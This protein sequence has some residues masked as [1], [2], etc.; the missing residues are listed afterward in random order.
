MR[1]PQTVCT[2]SALP[3]DRLLVL[4]ER[5]EREGR[6]RL[7]ARAALHTGEVIVGNIGSHARLDYTVIGDS[8]NL[9]SRLEGLNKRYGTSLMISETTYEKVKDVMVVRPLDRVSVKGKARSV[10][11]YE[12][13]GKRG[14]VDDAAVA[15]AERHR[16]AFS[17]YLER[18]FEEAATIFAG[19]AAERPADVA[20]K[21]LEERCRDLATAPPPAEGWTGAVQM[22]T[23]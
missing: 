8:V 16:H 21:V 23:K 18:R 22:T 10:D 11:V 12:L 15:R 14:E 2:S 19:L 1:S 6:P 9:A 17:L 20:A 7:D 4:N 5:W 3:P 13:L